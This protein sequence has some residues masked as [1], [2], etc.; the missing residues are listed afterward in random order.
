M[1]FVLQSFCR[2]QVA[3]FLFT[4]CICTGILVAWQFVIGYGLVSSSSLKM[5]CF[6]SIYLSQRLCCSN[7]YNRDTGVVVMLLAFL[8]GPPTHSIKADRLSFSYLKTGFL[9]FLKA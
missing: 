7:L 9:N 3:I 2:I 4:K 1:S 5:D 6:L 8:V